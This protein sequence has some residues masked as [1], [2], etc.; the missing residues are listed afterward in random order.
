MGGGRALIAGP[1]AS[2]HVTAYLR[3][4]EPHALKEAVA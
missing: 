3:T 2:T 1:A 4:Y